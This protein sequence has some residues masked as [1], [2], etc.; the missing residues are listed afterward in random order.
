MSDNMRKSEY[1]VLLEYLYN[2]EVA[3]EDELTQAVSNIRYRK[4]DITDCF[5]LAALIERHDTLKKVS[6]EIRTLLKIFNKG[7]E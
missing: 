3:V 6:N 5:E 2:N 4:I 7:K 1:I